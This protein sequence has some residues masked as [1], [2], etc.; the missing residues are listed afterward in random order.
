MCGGEL[1]G[2]NRF[3]IIERAKND[4]LNCTNIHTSPEEMAVLDCF[5]FRCWQMGWLTVYDDKEPRNKTADK[6]CDWIRNNWREYMR[7]P[8]KDGCISFGGW[9][10]DFRKA[11]E[12]ED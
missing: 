11:L 8:D 7:G 5:L 12:L 4:L 9:E 3:E 10:N 1:C 6:A 2:D